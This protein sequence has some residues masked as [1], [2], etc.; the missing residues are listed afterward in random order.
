M[1]QEVIFIN[2]MG[3]LLDVLKIKKTQPTAICFNDVFRDLFGIAKRFY[4]YL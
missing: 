2:F 3:F 4:L 1:Q